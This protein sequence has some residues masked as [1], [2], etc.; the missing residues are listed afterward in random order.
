MNSFSLPKYATKPSIVGAPRAFGYA[1]IKMR[2]PRKKKAEHQTN[3]KQ[4]AWGAKIPMVPTKFKTHH[5]NI[6]RIRLK[7]ATFFLM[8]FRFEISIFTLSFKP[9]FLL[10]TKFG[11]CPYMNMYKLITGAITLD[12]R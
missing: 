4:Y 12:V 1:K 11:W 10:L 7:K 5:E 6:S 8:I 9:L 2:F 3:G